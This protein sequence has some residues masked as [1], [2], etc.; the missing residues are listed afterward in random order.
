MQSEHVIIVQPAIKDTLLAIAMPRKQVAGGHETA[1]LSNRWHRLIW[2]RKVNIFYYR[3][4]F[5]ESV[6]VRT[7][8]YEDQSG[9]HKDILTWKRKGRRMSDICR[10][11]MKH[12]NR[13]VFTRRTGSWTKKRSADRNGSASANVSIPIGDRRMRIPKTNFGTKNMKNA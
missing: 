8:A 9:A 13:Q 11:Y 2:R 1:S 10:L 4:A 6:T 7:G 5:F 3:Q 12:N